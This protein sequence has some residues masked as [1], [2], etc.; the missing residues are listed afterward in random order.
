MNR[1]GDTTLFL[2]LVDAIS[3]LPFLLTLYGEHKA[4]WNPS[5]RLAKTLYGLYSWRSY[6]CRISIILLL[7]C[8]GFHSICKELF[9]FWK[10]FLRFLKISL[11]ISQFSRIAL[12]HWLPRLTVNFNELPMGFPRIFFSTNKGLPTNIW[13]SSYK[14]ES[15]LFLQLLNHRC[16][17]S[18]NQPVISRMSVNIHT[19]LW[20]NFFRS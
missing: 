6:D 13:C 11:F 14:L 7:Y 17:N 10:S 9:R 2:P 19:I 12:V 20:N 8:I 5:Q 18:R 15:L 16:Y 1:L 4:T 3:S